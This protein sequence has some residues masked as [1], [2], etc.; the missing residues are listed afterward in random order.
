MSVRRAGI[1]AFVSVSALVLLARALD[2]TAILDRLAALRPGW[3]AAALAISVLQMLALAWRWRFTAGR[4]GVRLRFR[5][6]L[7]EYYLGSFL[8]QVLPG[9]VTGDVAR[10]VRHARSDVPTPAAV[11]AVVLERLS[12]QV[13]MTSV[14]IA[15][16]ALLP[17]LG[18]GIRALAAVMLL[19]FLM[20]AFRG[21]TRAAAHGARPAGG[22]SV[23]RR[24]WSD[25]EHAVLAPGARLMQLVTA[26]FTV[27]SY[28]AVY[29]CA[30]EAVG[31]EVPWWVLAPLVA[32]VLMTMLL[33]ITVAGW[34]IREAAA[35]GL[36][37]GVGL[38]PEDG[39]AISVSYGVIVLASTAPGA[40]VLTAAAL[41]GRGR[42]ARPHRARSAEPAAEGHRSG[43]GSD[44]AS[45]TDAPIR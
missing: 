14:A 4:L 38:S 25:A 35:A 3:V 8:N 2:A 19:L 21:A 9:G 31:T 41:A 28:V 10:A 42:T 7:A 39:V 36:W 12:A 11:H 1:R 26:L 33:P 44:R 17:S 29:L 6:A 13:V 34:G 16:V 18:A 5:T 23:A 32:P 27:G 43:S 40:A 24:F 37:A 30:A 20:G 22:G 15:S 45:P